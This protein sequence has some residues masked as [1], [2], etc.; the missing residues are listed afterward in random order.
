MKQVQLLSPNDHT[1]RT[2]ITLTKELKR[3]I[4]AQTAIS[5]ESL[6][7]YLRQAAKLKLIQDERKEVDLKALADEVIG[8]IDLRKHPEWSTPQK[9][10]KWVRKLRAEWE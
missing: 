1:V 7:D 6:S 2:Q 8:S 9:V 10:R 3:Q 5:G 4:E